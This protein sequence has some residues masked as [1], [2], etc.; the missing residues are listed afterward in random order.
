MIK[1]KEI[2]RCVVLEN[3]SKSVQLSSRC[4]LVNR[5]LAYKHLQKGM[6]IMATIKSKEDHG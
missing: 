5:G 6:S 2:I 4:S 1:D 3:D